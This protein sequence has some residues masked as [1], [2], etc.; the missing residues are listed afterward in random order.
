MKTFSYTVVIVAIAC[1]VD[2]SVHGFTPKS[3]CQILSPSSHVTSTTSAS[4]SASRFFLHPNQASDLEACAY[5]L[6]KEAVHEE[7]EKTEIVKNVLTKDISKRLV[8]DDTGPVKWAKRK[9][10]PFRG[11]AGVEGRTKLP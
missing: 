8:M 7:K 11:G 1:A 3:G 2:V 9:L 10:W 6:M 4:S 5:D